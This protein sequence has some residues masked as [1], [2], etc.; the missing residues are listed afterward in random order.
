M[1]YKSIDRASIGR[2][3]SR[4]R[5]MCVINVAI[6]YDIPPFGCVYMHKY[7]KYI[8]TRVPPIPSHCEIENC[9]GISEG[10]R[11]SPISE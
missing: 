6:A 10:N 5:K 8:F 11:I 9:N 7:I 2:H 3:R 1:K 4:E